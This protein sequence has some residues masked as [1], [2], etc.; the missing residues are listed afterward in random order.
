MTSA[1]GIAGTAYRQQ[2]APDIERLVLDHT[3]LV[4]RLAWHVRGRANPGH[5]LAD[6]MQAGM[7]ALVEAARNYQD[8]GF[9]FSTYATT[10]VRGAMI[11][12]VRRQSTLTRSAILFR[13]A[14]DQ[15]RQRLEKSLGRPPTD[16]EMATAMSMASETYRRNAQETQDIRIES[17][18][19]SYSD[20]LAVFA[21]EE[22]AIED[23]I[24][25][26]AQ[27]AALASALDRLPHREATILQLYFLEEMNL[28]EIG[29]VLG[30]GAARICQIKKAALERLRGLMNGG[31]SPAMA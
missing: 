16:H 14:A 28:Q 24:D 1:T 4:R 7:V 15:A 12:F 27:A 21:L 13:R 26:Q 3:D 31:D 11:D 20:C 8:M 23:R 10:R 19:D 6:L 2:S 9:S 29:E 17:I 25:N 5:D 30:V 22:D 18:D